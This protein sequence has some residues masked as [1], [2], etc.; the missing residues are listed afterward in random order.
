MSNKSVTAHMKEIR[1]EMSNFDHSIDDGMEDAL[2]VG[3]CYGAHA[4]WNFYG[5][6]FYKDGKF[7]EEVWSYG[8]I[9]EVISADSLAELM[10]LVNEKYGKD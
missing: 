7:H 3:N 6:V 2:K 10:A 1:Q 5:R 4:A 9:I 8:G